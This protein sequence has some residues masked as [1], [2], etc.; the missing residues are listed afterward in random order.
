VD[1][2]E[3]AGRRWLRSKF[4]GLHPLHD[5][6]LATTAMQV[7][8]EI[9]GQPAAW[10]PAWFG[11]RPPGEADQKHFEALAFTVLQ[12][13]VTD[14]FRREYRDW[15]QSLEEVP[16][17]LWPVADMPDAATALARVRA[18]R[19]LLVLVEQMSPRDRLLIER[20]ALG[21]KSVALTGAERER[22]RWLR[23]HLRA[24]LGDLL[25]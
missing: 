2:V 1:F 20:V 8:S 12:R 15:M 13:R 16:Q 17:R 3:C 22:V 24:R 5:D 4:P 6:L 10:P 25:E 9:S 7:T 19:A 23:T 14:E 11:P 18:I 21:D